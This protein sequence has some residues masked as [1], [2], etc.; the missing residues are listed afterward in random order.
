MEGTNLRPLHLGRGGQ[1]EVALG[2]EGDGSAENTQ[3]RENR[4]ETR[5]F[6]VNFPKDM[7]ARKGPSQGRACRAKFQNPEKWEFR[8]QN[9]EKSGPRNP[10]KLNSRRV[11][12]PTCH[13]ARPKL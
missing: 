1:Y 2:V 6:E 12:R 8:F 3:S 11:E 4:N 9:P 7:G 10:G 5:S 13:W